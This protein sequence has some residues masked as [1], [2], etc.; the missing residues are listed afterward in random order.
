M[1]TL[2]S[3]YKFNNTKVI[4]SVLYSKEYKFILHN[5]T[6]F[7]LQIRSSSLQS[8]FLFVLILHLNSIFY[9]NLFYNFEI[10]LQRD[11]TKSERLSCAQLMA[12]NRVQIVCNST[13]VTSH[14]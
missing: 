10:N 3:I 5:V 11:M 12:G 2:I 8:E 7:L 4:Y 9:H 14:G 13:R 6:N 1:H